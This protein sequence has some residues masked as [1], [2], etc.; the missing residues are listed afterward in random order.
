MRIRLALDPLCDT[1]NRWEMHDGD[2]QYLPGIP[3][4]LYQTVYASHVSLG[5]R[6]GSLMFGRT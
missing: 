6:G 1:F 2:A 3:D 4:G 5:A